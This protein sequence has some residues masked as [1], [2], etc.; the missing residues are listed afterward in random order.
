MSR[1][2]TEKLAF[3]TV[4]LASLVVVLPAL[5]IIGFLAAKGAFAISWSFL[6]QMPK[7]G[8]REGGI[9]PAIVGTLYLVA[10]TL[11]FAVP[12]GVFAAIYLAEY[13]PQSTLRR[14]VRL[15]IVNLAGV[16][17][18]VYGLFGYGLFVVTLHFGKSILAG[19]LTLAFL[20]LPVVIAASEEAVR[21]VPKSFR[22]GSLALGATRWQ[23]IWRVVLPNA[24]GGIITGVVIGVGRAAGETAPIMFTAAAFFLPKLPSSPLSD[25][26]ALP[27]HLYVVASEMFDAPL[28][29]QWGTA[30]T[31]LMLVTAMNLVAALIRARFRR[32]KCW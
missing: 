1:N 10:G 25:C 7:N 19:S 21:S 32:A 26:M 5:V 20:I 22:E 28:S 27:Y 14:I 16:P 29:M 8:M 23:T 3:A 18:V 30:L 17:S 12:L 24:A 11:V 15:S 4:A 9:M 13:A 6:T 2:Q 31:L